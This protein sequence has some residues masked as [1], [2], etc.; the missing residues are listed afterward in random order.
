MD[1]WMECVIYDNLVS[2]WVKAGL[3]SEIGHK[4]LSASGGFVGD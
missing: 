1:F 3:I 4:Y 2:N